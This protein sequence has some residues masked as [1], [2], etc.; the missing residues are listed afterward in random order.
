[1]GDGT[2]LLLSVFYQIIMDHGVEILE[3]S[4][5]NEGTVFTV[6]LPNHKTGEEFSA[7]AD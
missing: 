1:M 5:P 3:E 7:K 4:E 2:G 6:V